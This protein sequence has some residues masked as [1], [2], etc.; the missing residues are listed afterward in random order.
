MSK[1]L[2]SWLLKPPVPPI[3]FKSEALEGWTGVAELV[4]PRLARAV[5]TR[6]PRVG[7]QAEMMPEAVSTTHQVQAVARVPVWMY[8]LAMAEWV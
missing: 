5:L 7:R 6:G 1:V 8:L 3:V 4:K 2:L